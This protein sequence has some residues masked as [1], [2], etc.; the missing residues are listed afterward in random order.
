MGKLQPASAWFTE[1]SVPQNP[2]ISGLDIC[3]YYRL[4]DNLPSNRSGLDFLQ[5]FFTKKL[6]SPQLLPFLAPAEKFCCQCHKADL[7][8]GGLCTSECVRLN[9]RQRID[10]G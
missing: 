2:L 5:D 10:E 1:G 4:K 7:P 3:R 8:D 6:V 9:R